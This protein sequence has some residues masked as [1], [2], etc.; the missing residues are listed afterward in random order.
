MLGSFASLEKMEIPT[1]YKSKNPFPLESSLKVKTDKKH[2]V[3]ILTEVPLIYQKGTYHSMRHYAQYQKE[4]LKTVAKDLFFSKEV[5]KHRG[6]ATL[7]YKEYDRKHVYDYSSIIHKEIA[8]KKPRQPR[9]LKPL[10]KLPPLIQ[11][12]IASPKRAIDNVPFCLEECIWKA[13]LESTLASSSSLLVPIPPPPPPPPDSPSQ[14]FL[15]ECHDMLE[16]QRMTKGWPKRG[17]TLHEPE[18]KDLEWEERLLRKLN[19]ATAQW[20]VNSQS[21]WGGW[22][23]ARP[24]SFKKQ[25][26]DWGRIRY[27]LP[28]GSDMELLDEIMA[29]EDGAGAQSF[30]EKISETPLPVY[31]R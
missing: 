1:F 7:S 21:S 26:Y 9:R 3:S 18:D 10:K 25:K 14:T 17:I 8:T 2:M 27:V 24:K 22:V 16:P 4:C 12:D 15:T 29:K 31:Y 11:T 28:C 19:K 6:P 30:E 23:Q 20:I 13:K 5:V